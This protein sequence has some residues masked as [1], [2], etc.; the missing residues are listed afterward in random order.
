MFLKKTRYKNGKTFLS[1]V[2]AYRDEN[3]KPKQRLILKIGYLDDFTDKY[4]DPIAHFTDVAKNMTIDAKKESNVSLSI[5]MNASIDD[6]YNLFNVGYLPFKYIYNELGINEFFI[7]KQRNLDIEFSLS[8][9]LQLLVFSRILFPS[10]KKSTFENRN[11]F[12]APFNDGITKD[13]IYKSLDYFYHYK[14]EIEALIWKNTKDIYNRDISKSY[15]DCTNYYFEIEYNDD[16][17]IDE[18]GEIVEKGLRKRGPEKN[19]RPDPIV[20]MGLLMDASG[21]PLAYDLFPGNESE[22]LSLRPLLK[23]TKADFGIQRTIVV[24]DRGLN[25]SDNIYFLAGKNDKK[26]HHM[27]GYVYG[28]SIRG[29]DKK[30]KAW[31]LDGKDYKVDFI[32]EDGKS[33]AF[34]HKSR[35]YAKEIKILR[36]GKREVKVNICQKQMVYFSFKYLMKQRKDRNKMI[37]KAEEMIRN[38]AAYTKATT[39]GAAGYV[40]NLEFDAKTGE[41]KTGKTL[42]IDRE[43]IA[44]EEK[45]D[46]YY[47]IVTSEIELDD[48]E[49]RKIYRGLAKIEDT[50]KVTKSNFGA[51]PVFVWTKEHIEGH[52]F[53]CFIALVIMRLLE[54]KLSYKY[55]SEQIID[56]TKKYNCINIDKNIYQFIYKDRIIDD[57]SEIFNVNLNQKY[58]RREKIK[59]LLKY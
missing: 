20:E 18:N 59:K 6:G 16:D 3:G 22:K 10:S 23:K 37:K 50:F 49:I 56:S 38:P 11:R 47:S 30:F 28:Q 1:I 32:N 58:E 39:Y 2:E 34:T 45:Y 25:T 36:D 4:D 26:S 24:A 43:K 5:D 33:I 57:I 12:F 44:E 9:N 54:R 7:N 35:T 48:Y 41:I 53:T 55:T 27:D 42:F 14:E 52:F 40:G 13:S 19:H 8:R 46:G 21:I 17:I 51:R 29:A 31:V 15:Y